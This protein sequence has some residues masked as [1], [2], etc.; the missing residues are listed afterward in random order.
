MVGIAPS[1]LAQQPK[2]L[3]A[4]SLEVAFSARAEIHHLAQPILEIANPDEVASLRID[5]VALDESHHQHR[6][7]RLTIEPGGRSLLGFES[8]TGFD[9]LVLRAEGRFHAELEDA[10]SGQT[11]VLE[12]LSAEASRARDAAAKTT[13]ACDG[14]WNLT[15]IAPS[16][17]TFVSGYK[18]GRVEDGD[19][20][21]WNL[22]TPTGPWETI[23]SGC[24]TDWY[25]ILSNGC[26]S[27]A[28]N[29]WGQTYSIAHNLPV[30][31]PDLVVQNLTVT[32][33]SATSG[34]TVSISYDVKNVGN[35]TA[36]QNYQERI[37]LQPALGSAQEI[38][39]T[40]AH[41][42]DL[43]PQGVQHVTTN[44]DVYGSAGPYTLAVET[45]FL[46]VVP[47]TNEINNFASRSFTAQ[48]PASPQIVIDGLIYDPGAGNGWTFAL[49]NCTQGVLCT[50]TFKVKSVGFSSAFFSLSYT[51]Q[52]GTSVSHT[53]P[54][55]LAPG[56]SCTITVR[57]TLPSGTAQRSGGNIDPNGTIFPSQSDYDICVED[58]D[59]L[60]R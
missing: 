51:S 50:R 3:A 22:H 45:D 29:C 58:T 60:C 48:T 23:G 25:G 39:V 31:G 20:V 5:V 59:W 18:A 43:A 55:S 34:S 52:N 49:Q 4:K 15:C 9:R 24:T 16:G 19:Q 41:V 13:V 35:Q 12:V 21:Y 33:S 28:D 8:L 46:K 2:P 7:H 37:T 10:S 17:C 57:H 47:E 53:C 54:S 27:F 30:S 1:A 11:E 32:P 44:V 36:T 26:P 14:T 56:S 6:R 40:S 42:L 38:W